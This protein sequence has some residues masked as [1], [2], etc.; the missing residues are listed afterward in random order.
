MDS[1]SFRVVEHLEVGEGLV[2]QGPTPKRICLFYL[3]VPE[4]HPL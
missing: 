1:K 3:A 4:S 2:T